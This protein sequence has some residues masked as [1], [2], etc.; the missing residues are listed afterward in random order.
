MHAARL[1]WEK[2]LALDPTSAALNGMLSS[3]HWLDA[4]FGWWDDRETALAKARIYADR[5]LE[6]DPENAD[7][8]TASSIALAMKGQYDEAVAHARRAVE[9]A[10][11][12]ADAAHFASFVLASA[13]YTKDAV[14]ESKRA[15]ALNPNYPPYYLGNLGYALRLAGQV[16]E[17]IT[18][19]K[20]Y[21]AQVPGSGFGLTDLVILY[22]QSG[23]P[24]QAKQTAE[25]FLLARPDFTITSWLKTQTIRDAAHLEADVN[26]LRSAGLPMS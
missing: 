21:D 23:Q 13:G 22:Q 20:A 24:D 8:V 6:L 18:A 15:M 14:G 12:S 2:A 5:A 26:A 7:A 11:G 9:L 3:A 19:F 17:A 16:E 4:R 10:P 1:C 25:R